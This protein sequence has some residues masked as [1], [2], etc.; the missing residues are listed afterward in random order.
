MS[1]APDATWPVTRRASTVPS[2]RPRSAPRSNRRCARA[3]CGI[4]KASPCGGPLQGIGKKE[5]LVRPYGQFVAGRI[6]KM[7][8]PSAREGI[9]RLDDHAAGVGDGRQA[10]FEVVTIENDQRFLGRFGRIGLETTVEAGIAG[11][12]IGRAVID[13]SPAKGLAVER[14][15]R[16]EVGGGKFD[17]VDVMMVFCHRIS[18]QT[19]AGFSAAS[20]MSAIV[21]TL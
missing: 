9:D 2:G 13:E 21:R 8:A 11:R 10:G 16:S 3:R 5:L 20:S 12:R 15:Q 6:G 17:I 14:F 7:K 4:G 1:Y 18:S 19:A